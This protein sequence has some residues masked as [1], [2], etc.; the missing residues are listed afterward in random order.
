MTQQ[1]IKGDTGYINTHP[2]IQCHPKFK[3][4]FNAS[5]LAE[6]ETF[7]VIMVKI[8]NTMALMTQ[9]LTEPGTG[10]GAQGP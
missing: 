6:T 10:N 9:K 5:A 2:I 7:K 4:E 3:N 8:E 1:R